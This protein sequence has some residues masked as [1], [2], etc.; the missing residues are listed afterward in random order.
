[1]KQRTD[2]FNDLWMY[3]EIPMKRDETRE[4]CRRTAI[5]RNSFEQGFTVEGHELIQCT[6]AW[7]SD[8]R[9]DAI[10]WDDSQP[11]EQRRGSDPLVEPSRVLEHS[12]LKDH[13][14]WQWFVFLQRN[15]WPSSMMNRSSFFSGTILCSLVS[16]R[17]RNFVSRT[18]CRPW[19]RRFGCAVNL[20]GS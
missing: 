19:P 3:S 16:V 1:M 5:V 17:V 6:P 14:Q 18:S 8:W 4:G 12:N 10:E 7:S 15:D 11:I 2:Q 13:R 20:S 9:L